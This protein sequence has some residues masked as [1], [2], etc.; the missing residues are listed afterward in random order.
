MATFQKK[1]FVQPDETRDFKHGQLD[2]VTVSGMTFGRSILEPGW[3]WSTCM[4]PLE[5]TQWC[6][7][8]HMQYH[9]SGQ[10]RVLLKDGTEMDFGPGDVAWIPPCQDAWVVGTDRVTVID[11]GGSVASIGKP[12][13]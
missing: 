11:I 1:N 4:R 9:L 12:A 5:K 10:L 2:L 3:R 6:E 7:V 8:P 13:A